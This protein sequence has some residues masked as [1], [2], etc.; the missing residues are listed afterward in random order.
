MTRREHASGDPVRDVLAEYLDASPERTRAWRLD[1][2]FSARVKELRAALYVVDDGLLAIGLA[3]STRRNLLAVLME[4]PPDA[5]E[6]VARVDDAAR[7]AR[8]AAPRG[9]SVLVARPVVEPGM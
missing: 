7:R 8:D 2:R 4:G 5:S 1:P 6:A 9:P 3:E